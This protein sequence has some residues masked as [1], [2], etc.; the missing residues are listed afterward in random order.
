MKFGVITLGYNVE[1]FIQDNID[2]V[3]KQVGCDFIHFVLD[4]AS[5]DATSKILEEEASKRDETFMVFT[6]PKRTGST[7]S[8][9]QAM[10]FAPLDDEDVVIQ[11]DGDDRFTHENVL[12]RVKEEYDKGFLATYGNYKVEGW[13]L[14][15]HLK[16]AK[17][18]CGPK[19]LDI[20]VRQ[21]LDQPG[22]RYSALRTFKRWLFNR[23]PP[24]S[25]VDFDGKIYSSAQDLTFFLPII[26]LIGME[27]LSFIDEELMIYNQHPNNDYVE[28]GA[29]SGLEDMERCT[30]ELFMRPSVPKLGELQDPANFLE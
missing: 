14:G 16:L 21:Q 24:W 22:W 25:Y 8:W 6:K 2:S 3:K 19:I 10:E 20:P 7:H 30:R 29:G 12:S 28:G 27:N 17:S 18:V 9:L 1:K 13:K 26:E 23:V 15:R 5:T 11:L 4:D